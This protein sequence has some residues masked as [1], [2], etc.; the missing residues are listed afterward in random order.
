MSVMDEWNE[1]KKRHAD[2]QKAE[3]AYRLEISETSD[4]ERAELEIIRA[5]RKLEREQLQKERDERREIREA[6]KRELE[7][8]RKQRAIIRKERKARLEAKRAA[9]RKKR[10]KRAKMIEE[11]TEDILKMAT[12]GNMSVRQISEEVGLK[13]HTVM[14]IIWENLTEEE[15][16][17]RKQVVQSKP[18]DKLA[19]YTDQDIV[20]AIKRAADDL[21]PNFGMAKYMKWRDK[22][23]KAARNKLPSSGIISRR[24]GWRA[25]REMAGLETPVMK[26]D[27]FGTQKYSD[28]DIFRAIDSWVFR[29]GGWITIEDA[30][31]FSKDDPDGTPKVGVIRIRFEGSWNTVRTAYYQWK[32]D[33]S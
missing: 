15:R 29:K 23:P 4:L 25:Y 5:Q 22:H 30:I 31:K 33:L 19:K 14:A 7:A 6:R 12:H 16:Q 20:D 8:H 13:P 28:E 27:G 9:L 2:K 26:I 24:K 21:G 32:G 11:K 3:M 1:I 10:E 18:K 17:L